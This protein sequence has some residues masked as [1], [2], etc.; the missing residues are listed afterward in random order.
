MVPF[1]LRSWSFKSELCQKYHRDFNLSDLHVKMAGH[2]FTTD[3]MINF[4]RDILGNGVES[5][6]GT[7]IHKMNL[8]RMGMPGFTQQLSIVVTVTIQKKVL[9]K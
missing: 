5:N 8:E 6:K 9:R 1:S 4:I 2:Y 3:E 7:Y